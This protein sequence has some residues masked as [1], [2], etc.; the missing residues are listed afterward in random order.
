MVSV[1]VMLLKLAHYEVKQ[2]RYSQHAHAEYHT[3]L[4]HSRTTTGAQPPDGTLRQDDD[5]HIDHCIEDP[6]DEVCRVDVNIV[7]PTN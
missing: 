2:G 6:T 4:P 5:G 3:C 7:P 1:N